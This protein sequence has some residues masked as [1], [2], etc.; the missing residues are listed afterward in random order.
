[1]KRQNHYFNGRLLFVSAYL[2]LSTRMSYVCENN[3]PLCWSAWTKVRRREHFNIQQKYGK[4]SCQRNHSKM[5]TR[6]ETT[7]SFARSTAR[8]PLSLVPFSLVIP[9]HPLSLAVAFSAAPVLVVLVLMVSFSAVLVGSPSFFDCLQKSA[10]FASPEQE[11][12]PLAFDSH[13]FAVYQAVGNTSVC[14]YK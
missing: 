10:R 6:I 1:M 8:V 2:T 12:K 4:E 11:Y 5:V 7:Y 14:L 3:T 13:Y 9:Y